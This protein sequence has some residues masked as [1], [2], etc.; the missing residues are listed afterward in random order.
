MKDLLFDVPQTNRVARRKDFR[1]A[2][3]KFQQERGIWTHRST[4]IPGANWSA[5]LK[6]EAMKLLADYGPEVATMEPVYLIATYGRLLEEANLLVYGPTH[7]ATIE[8]LCALN[9]IEMP[10]QEGK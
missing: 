7:R 9:G 3:W 5:L 6:P 8:K 4:G 10:K 1:E 2:L